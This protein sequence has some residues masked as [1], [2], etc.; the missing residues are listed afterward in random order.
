GWSDIGYHFILDQSGRVYQGRPFLDESIKFKDGPP[1]ALGAHVG[2]S[3]TGNI[4]VSVL[5]CYHP[6]EGSGCRDMLSPA[7][8]DSLVTLFAFL[9]ETYGVTPSII[10]GHRDY[11]STACPGDNNYKLLPQIR[12]RVADLLVTGNRPVGTAS[13][14]AT[15]NPDGVV[16]LDWQF[17]T[18]R[19]ITGFTI[20]RVTPDGRTVL[21]SGESAQDMT[22][23]DDEVPT[24]G[25]VRYVLTA[26]NS[27]G[28]SQELAS[29]RV[30]IENPEQ[31]K[32][33]NSF[34]NPFSDATTIR[35]YL[36][37]DGFVS[38]KV[39]DASGRLVDVLEDS[40]LEKGRWY[41]AHFQANDLPS[42]HYFYRI[43]VEGFSGVVFDESGSLVLAR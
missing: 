17:L 37:Q 11:S 32:L 42:G 7:A 43:M 1:L 14:N 20:E 30:D 4:G 31:F 36:A 2:G 23:T 29:I 5:G 38:L 33:S 19:G 12:K 13:L 34:P 40:F 21:F 25:E 9:S 27:D 6:P 41:T 10:R 39:F 3:N 16:N 18:D 26:S 8:L 15:V 22:L 28:R 35:Y 24:T